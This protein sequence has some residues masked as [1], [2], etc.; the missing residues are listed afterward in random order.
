MFLLAGTSAGSPYIRRTCKKCSIPFCSRV[1]RVFKSLTRCAALTQGVHSTTPSSPKPCMHAPCPVRL[2][3]FVAHQPPWVP[4]PGAP[5][6]FDA[7]DHACHSTARALT[8]QSMT[9]A[10]WHWIQ[11]AHVSFQCSPLP[12]YRLPHHC[13][14]PHTHL[15]L[16]AT[17]HSCV[18]CT[19]SS[20]EAS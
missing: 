17:V 18:P 19:F 7:Q 3:G 14:P 6:P 1:P 11:L 9:A 8:H 20:S 16:P 5:A 4:G 13:S 15:I 12:M 2:P 10:G